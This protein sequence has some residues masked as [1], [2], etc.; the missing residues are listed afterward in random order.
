MMDSLTHFTREAL[1]AVIDGQHVRFP[2][3]RQ[4]F[5]STVVGWW[6]SEPGVAVVMGVGG[7][8]E[9]RTYA[10][11]LVAN[12]LASFGYKR[13]Q[14]TIDPSPEF[15]KTADW[16]DIMAKAKRLI[17]SQQVTLL[18]NGW[19]NIVGHVIG[20]HG[21]YNT[22][23]GRDDPS[24]RAITTWQCDCLVPGTGII[25][26]DGSVKVVEDVQVG[27]MVMT[28][29]GRIKAVTQ[30]MGRHY[31]GDLIGIR[32]S[33]FTETLWTTVEHPIMT[34]DEGLK[35]AER[36]RQG[37]LCYFPVP[38]DI[39]STKVI[40]VW[41]YLD[42]DRFI[43]YEGRVYKR[44]RSYGDK[45]QPKR[46]RPKTAH[47]ERYSSI[48][49]KIALSS[50][51]G[52]LLGLYVAE[53]FT[54]ARGEIHWSFNHA[55][56]EHLVEEVQVELS[57]L[58]LSS[59]VERRDHTLDVATNSVQMALV[60]EALIGTGSRTKRL[61][62]PIIHGDLEFLEALFEAW[63]DGDGYRGHAS[64]TT[65]STASSDLAMQARYILARLG[66]ESTHRHRQDNSSDLVPGGQDIHHVIWRKN[67]GRGIGR[68]YVEGNQVIH[69]IIEP[70]RKSYSGKVYNLEVEDD[71]T[72]VAYPGIAV[73]NCDW[74]QYAFNRTRQWKKY[75]GRPCS[76]VLALFWSSLAAPLDDHDES[77]HG[78]LPPGQKAAPV[79]PPDGGAPAAPPAPAP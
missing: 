29:A 5:G 74:D 67:G 31:E 73:H 13:A 3:R 48:P 38:E 52:R 63:V 12:Q 22:E 11:R 47:C 53:G 55:G 41:D 16:S 35:E 56:E 36:W 23:I 72:Y 46:R 78:P 58:G 44:N 77:V 30:T 50:G 32:P 34:P 9:E 25:M 14:F 54:T 8:A 1:T 45:R 66:H 62:A 49:A 70:E 7:P 59:W 27:D 65:L 64:R 71:H 69:E 40:D 24:S 39:P 76:H 75:E 15:R 68:H 10:E 20:D 61:A 26:H 4:R 51:L 28:A 33:G 17:E 57:R 18:R 43:E 19:N 6:E 42:T 60:I 79:P 37:D 21:E 2:D